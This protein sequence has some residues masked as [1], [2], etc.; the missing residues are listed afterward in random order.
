MK[1]SQKLL[2]IIIRHRPK[3]FEEFMG[4]KSV[5]DELKAILPKKNEH[6]F[7][8]TGPIGCGKTTLAR[9]MAKELDC[10]DQYYNL[11]EKN[12][13]DLTGVEEMRKELFRTTFAT[14]RTRIFDEAHK[15]TNAAQ[16][17]ALKYFEEPTSSAY[18][19]LCTDKPDKIIPALKSRCFNYE[20]R[21]L[22]PFE[23]VKLLKN[24]CK[25][26]GKALSKD[27]LYSIADASNGIPREALK[28]LETTL[29]SHRLINTGKGKRVFIL[30][31]KEDLGFLQSISR[32]GYNYE[33]I[34]IG[35]SNFETLREKDV[36]IIQQ[37][38]EEGRNLTENFLRKAEGIP[39]SLKIIEMPG[40]NN[41][42]FEDWVASHGNIPSSESILQRLEKIID[43][44]PEL[45]FPSL[46]TAPDSLIMSFGA[47]NRLNL[48]KRKIIMSP[49]LEEGSLV[50]ISAHPGVGK[51]FLAMEIAAA[52]SWG[53]RAMDGLWQVENPIPVLYIEG[54]MHWEDLKS[55]SKP[56]K[57]RKSLLLA[58]VLYE[59]KNG[60]PPLNIAD[61]EGIRN[62]LTEYII[63]NGVKLLIL[64]NI[65]SLVLGLDHNF[66]REWSPI[67]QW[68]LFLRNKGIAVIIVHHTG[69]SGDQLGTSS[70]KFNIDYSL[71]LKKESISKKKSGY[72]AF[73]IYVDKQR[74]PVKSHIERI[75]IWS[76][77]DWEI[78]DLTKSEN[79]LAEYKKLKIAKMI[80]GGIA[81]KNIAK[82]FKCTRANISQTKKKLIETNLIRQVVNSETLTCEFTKKG[83]QWRNDVEKVN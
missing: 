6:S 30:Q 47:F 9:I 48:P 37:K 40:E 13:A 52:C 77:H 27:T 75:F 18:L 45:Q 60:Y 63:R 8:I 51:T 53:R 41:K 78:R 23:T 74:R 34:F 72:C 22:L 62:P 16:S 10:E 76:G 1:Q 50:L 39:K 66:E 35:L 12:C 54:E 26:E 61:A 70:R 58:K 17:A 81:N 7:L 79:K 49:W 28:I 83:N 80:V 36:I 42:S 57:L 82:A 21:P 4:N 44:P 24:V 19:I 3:S 64:D 15:L 68:L 56:L 67:N 38:S 46:R 32:G 33:S 14:K 73:R 71:M 20:L 2:P 59:H 29:S 43:N 25:K 11:I 69:K 5:T 31:R 55:R 65:Y